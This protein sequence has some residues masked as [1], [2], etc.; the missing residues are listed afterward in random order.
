MHSK[1]AEALKLRTEPVAIL[2][3]DERPEGAQG[4][5]GRGAGCALVLLAQAASR[6][7]TAAFDR[8]NFGCMGA[9]TGL[10]FG[11]QQDSFPLGGVEA[12]KF[13]LSSGLEGKGKDELVEKAKKLGSSEMRE[14]FLKGEGYKKTPELVGNFLKSLPV[15]EVPTKYVVFKPLRDLEEKDE[16]VV[17]VFVANS[18]QI[19]ALVGLANYDRPGI[20]N[21]VTPMGAGCHQICIDAYREAERDSPR[22]VLGLTDP[23]ARKNV[24]PL[25]GSD[26]F[27]FAVPYRRFLEMEAC[28]GESFLS[29]CTWKSLA[30]K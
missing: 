29:R 28:V 10:G 4:F 6:G 26:V 1:I 23:S 9:G 20:E 14:N 24:R 8:E 11:M 17:V 2:W 12:F 5:K 18:D 22:A 30:E 13:F 3:T 16:P 7:R 27:T 15:I 19:S 21:V 25:L